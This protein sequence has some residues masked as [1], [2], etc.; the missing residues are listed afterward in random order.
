MSAATC[1]L[2]T[3]AC[4]VMAIGRCTGC[5]R[6]FC[7]THAA[8]VL[9]TGL[10]ATSSTDTCSD[11]ADR[12][13]EQRQTANYIYSFLRDP[14][15]TRELA[16][17]MR[18]V[19]C[20]GLVERAVS[21]ER[22][23][24]YGWKSRQQRTLTSTR[25]LEPAW[26]V[27]R[28]SWTTVG[29]GKDPKRSSRSESL[30]VTE[31]GRAVVMYTT[32]TVVTGDPNHM[33]TGDFLPKN[34]QRLVHDGWDSG[35]ET[36]EITIGLAIVADANGLDAVRELRAVASDALQGSFADFDSLESLSA[37]AASRAS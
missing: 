7:R 9:R 16:E 29:G 17:R 28:L 2:S 24:A 1:E 6:A 22:T 25:E 35:P 27:G 12:H 4:N 21:V 3:P 14:E 5:A 30:G 36:A 37:L 19:S 15:T 32:A 18:L 34:N 11:C 10:G 20:P 13:R 33:D 8:E 26:P 23:E 31:G